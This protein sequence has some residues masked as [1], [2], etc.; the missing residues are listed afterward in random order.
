MSPAFRRLIPDRRRTTSFVLA[1][2]V[3]ALL[4]LILLIFGPRVTIEPKAKRP[5]TF[6]LAP[7]SDDTASTAPDRAKK[8]DNT[9]K[10]KSASAPPSTLPP[11][12]APPPKAPP[13]PVALPGVLPIELGSTD[14]SKIK[15]S[16]QGNDAG[17][18]DDSK[19]AY[20]PGEGP[21]GMPLYRAEWYREPSN[22]E[23][24]G[25]VKNL[26]PSGGWALIACKT[27]ANYHVENCRS[28]GESPVGSG[29]GRDMRLAA[30]QF[31]VRPP[32]RGGKP[33]IGAWVSIRID[34]HVT[35]VKRPAGPRMPFADGPKDESEDTSNGDQ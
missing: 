14:I 16:G 28:I 2:A 12:V 13:P 22:A 25:Y 3:E 4:I 29:L 33:L 11:D 27:V 24:N 7:P 20:G 10:P 18:S 31:L 6:A 30:W 23:L 1:L 15:G 21:G 9:P 35:V 5:I 19:L 32:R 17:D 8:A 34:F 26:P